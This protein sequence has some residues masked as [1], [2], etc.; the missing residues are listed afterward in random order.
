MSELS[1]AECVELCPD[2]ALGIADARDRASVLEHVERCRSCREEL[3]TLSAVADALGELVP[4][5]EPP[6]GFESRVTG[7]I[8]RPS[9]AEPRAPYP[10]RSYVRPLSVAAAVVVAA[11]IGVGGWL[12]A[13]GGSGPSVSVA[14]SSFV[15]NHR[16]VGE[17]MTV[18]GKKPW[19]SVA[20]HLRTGT[21]VVRCKV[22]NSEGTWRTVGT[23]DLYEGWGYWAAPLPS[24][25]AIRSAELLTPSGRVLATASVAQ[26]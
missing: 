23:F 1:C 19:I 18:A 13:R 2:V 15:S 21:N 22:E 24:G 25:A 11:A 10:R 8:S 12:A 9:R 5:V 26:A 7:S 16:A 3:G 20:V 14:T 4:P 6:P 17:V